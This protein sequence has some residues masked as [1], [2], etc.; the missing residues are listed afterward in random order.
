MLQRLIFA[1]RLTS[2]S[3]E[4]DDYCGIDELMIINNNLR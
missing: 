1:N 3:V 2:N 4:F